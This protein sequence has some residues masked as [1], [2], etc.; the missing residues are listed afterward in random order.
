MIKENNSQNQCQQSIVLYFDQHPQLHV[1]V[2]LREM[3]GDHN[4]VG[5][6]DIVVLVR[7]AV[8]F[9]LHLFVGVAVDH[10]TLVFE[11][12]EDHHN[13]YTADVQ[14]ALVMILVVAA[15]VVV[16]IVEEEVADVGVVEEEM[17]LGCYLERTNRVREWQKDYLVGETYKT[18][19]DQAEVHQLSE[20]E[21]E[22]EA[23]LVAVAAAAAAV[24]IVKLEKNWLMVKDD[25]SLLNEFA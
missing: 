15:A 19:V 9:Q 16:V 5:R 8:A 23:L 24:R 3:A 2:M 20:E 13:Y 17:K 11:L 7:K 14:E 10:H 6:E 4:P 12:E 21:S 25:C 1:D 22:Q 18:A